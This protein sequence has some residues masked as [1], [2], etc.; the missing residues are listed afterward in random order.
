MSAF[1]NCMRPNGTY[2]HAL[3]VVLLGEN[4]SNGDNIV[5]NVVAHLGNV[6]DGHCDDFRDTLL[7]IQREAEAA[8]EGRHGMTRDDQLELEFRSVLCSLPPDRQPLVV[9]FLRHLRET[10]QLDRISALSRGEIEMY[11]RY[12]RR[13]IRG[14]GAAKRGRSRIA[15]NWVKDNSSP[16]DEQGGL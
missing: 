3:P 7:T 6:L 11:F 5:A 8:P 15:N 10:D 2:R 14:E 13:R 1:F 4:N 9:P 16:E 12:W